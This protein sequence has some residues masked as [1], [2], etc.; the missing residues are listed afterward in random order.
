M[1]VK[2]SE[3]LYQHV[4]G[5]LALGGIIVFL[6]FVIFVFPSQASMDAAP[7]EQYFSPD[8]SLWY[9]SADL[10]Q[11]AE[12]YGED[13]RAEFVKAHFTFDLVWPAVYLFTLL[14]ATSWVFG[15]LTTPESGWRWVNLLPIA[16]VIFDLMENISTSL[17]MVLYPGQAPVIAAL[18]PIFTLVKWVLL[19]ASVLLLLVGTVIFGWRKVI[20][21]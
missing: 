9:S 11:L 1:F 13:G 5:W 8:T 3:W 14:M 2:L 16:G 19:G 6:L 17:V 20:K 10:Y 15:K 21:R 7:G 4:N 18:A 12:R